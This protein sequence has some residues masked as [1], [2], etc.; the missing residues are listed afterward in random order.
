MH[1]T[2]KSKWKVTLLTFMK[3]FGFIIFKQNTSDDFLKHFGRFFLKYYL[4]KIGYKMQRVQNVQCIEQIS[5]LD[6]P[7]SL[8]T[9][10][11]TTYFE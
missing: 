8:N 5:I 9:G 4:H 1:Q 7:R 2:V 6:S 3:M 11:Y 10:N